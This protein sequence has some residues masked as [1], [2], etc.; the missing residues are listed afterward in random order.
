MPSRALT[1][2]LL[3]AVVACGLVEGRAEPTESAGTDDRYPVLSVVDGDTFTVEIDGEEERV[4]LIGINAPEIGECL[5]DL[6]TS[7]LEQ[8]VGGALLRLDA[9]VADR[10]EFGRLLRYAYV[11]DDFVNVILVRRG[12]AIAYRYEPNVANQEALEAAEA[13]AR[14]D[15]VGMWSPD[16]CPSQHDLRIG[17]FHFDAIGNDDENLEDEWIEIVNPGPD[18]VP[19]AGWGLKDESASNR[20][21]FPADTEIMGD[22]SVIVRSGCGTDSADELFWCALRSVWTNG[23]DTA[24]LIDPG[25]NIADYRSYP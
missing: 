13:K 24:F 19:L 1:P 14:T 22:G 17:E 15:Q 23:G 5:A 16:A 3:V 2:L 21:H 18:A 9:D 11:A 20:Y 10:D 6:A 8:L 7:T 4:R 25:G 12:L